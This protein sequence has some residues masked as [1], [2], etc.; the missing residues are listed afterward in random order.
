MDNSML[1]E[2]R[3]E[4]GRLLRRLMKK[5]TVRDD[6]ASIRLMRMKRR[7]W[8]QKLFRKYSHQDLDD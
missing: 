5:N 6:E 8:I 3:T 4:A 1:G 7:K 2:Q